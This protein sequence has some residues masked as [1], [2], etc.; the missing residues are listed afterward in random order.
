MYSVLVQI[1]EWSRKHRKGSATLEHIVLFPLFIILSLVVWQLILSGMAVMDAH[2]AVRDAIR[3]ASTTGDIDQ[4]EKQGKNS[5]GQSGSYKLKRLEVKIENEEA[6][7]KAE[8]EIPILF[9]ASTPITFKTEEKAPALSMYN[10]AGPLITGSGQ[11]GFPVANPRISSSFGRRT[12]PVYGGTRMHNGIDFPGPIG[13]PIYAA[14]DGIV[15]YAGP[16]RGYGYLVI[17]DH[18]GGLETWYAHMYPY[19]VKVF[20][21]QRVKRGQQIAAIGNNGKSTGPHLHFEVRSG[22]VPVDPIPYLTRK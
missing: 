20:T 7:A 2:A 17:V 5:F 19:Q 14:A 3:V 22:G 13:T 18:G 21:G 8:V 15:K 9:M 10:F 1:V 12:D 11:L 4:A 16:A 6:I